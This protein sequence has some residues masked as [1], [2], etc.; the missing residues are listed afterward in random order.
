M[1]FAYVDSLPALIKEGGSRGIGTLRFG[2]PYLT[3][4]GRNS[5]TSFNSLSIAGAPVFVDI[6][7][8]DSVYRL[9]CETKR[10]KKNQLS[11]R[12]RA[13]V[14][15]AGFEF[16]IIPQFDCGITVIPHAIPLR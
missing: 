14:Y 5:S 6:E 2:P 12:P 7:D 3:S 4:P 1:A 10:T 8:V 11:D 9:V 13:A 16:S 15:A